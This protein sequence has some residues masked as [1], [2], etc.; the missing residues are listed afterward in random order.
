MHNCSN[1]LRWHMLTCTDLSA[2]SLLLLKCICTWVHTYTLIITVQRYVVQYWLQ[3]SCVS[4]CPRHVI[5]CMVLAIL[6]LVCVALSKVW[7]EVLTT[8][9][10]CISKLNCFFPSSIDYISRACRLTLLL[11]LLHEYSNWQRLLEGKLWNKLAI[12][13]CAFVSVLTP[14]IKTQCSLHSF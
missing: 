2:S 11:F 1:R 9:L 13:V 14:D 4:C 6:K 10:V 7:G 3:N 5:L 8:E 12:Y